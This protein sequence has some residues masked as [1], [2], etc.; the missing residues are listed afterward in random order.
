MKIAILIPT[1]YRPDGLRRSLQSLKD[2]TSHIDNVHAIVAAEDDDVD[3]LTI[4]HEYRASFTI[5]EK[6][7][8]GPAEGWNTALKAAIDYDAYFTGS[9]DIE[10]TPGWLDEVLRVL[11]DELNDSGLVGINDGRWKRAK[12]MQMCATHY[13]MTR[14]F[15]IDHMGGV[16]AQPFYHADFTDMEACARARRVGKF[17]WAENALVRHHWN[18]PHG[19]LG[20]DRATEQRPRMKPLYEKRK[21][22]NFPN[23]FEAILT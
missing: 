21:E 23:D 22:M 19:D 17:A 13:L 9:D 18:G 4:A 12:V 16:A 1:I 14:D 6:Y 7:R 3:A 10:F 2:T 20:Y 5:C 15:I 8:N 11:H